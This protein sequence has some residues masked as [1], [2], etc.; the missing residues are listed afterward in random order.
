MGEGRHHRLSI[1]RIHRLAKTKIHQT[2]ERVRAIHTPMPSAA[3]ATDGRTSGQAV[4]DHRGEQILQRSVAQGGPEKRCSQS[5][6]AEPNGPDRPERTVALDQ[7]RV[8]VERDER[9]LHAAAAGQSQF[10]LLATAVQQREQRPAAL[11]TGGQRPA[12][13]TAATPKQLPL[14]TAFLSAPTRRSSNGF[15]IRKQPNLF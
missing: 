15:E 8:D 5:D 13:R 7:T 2:T 11:W 10:Q 4:P 3:S 1:R 12:V 14:S 9:E 6:D